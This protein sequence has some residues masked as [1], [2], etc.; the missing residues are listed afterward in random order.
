MISYLTTD[1]NC[2]TCFNELIDV[3]STTP[4]VERVEPH[5]VDGC[6]AVTAPPHGPPPPWLTSTRPPSG[7]VDRIASATTCAS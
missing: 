6:I 3:I 7:S 1:V 5:V 4:G 2:P